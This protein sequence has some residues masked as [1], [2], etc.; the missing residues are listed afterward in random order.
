MPIIEIKLATTY[1]TILSLVLGFSTTGS[2]TTGS[3]TVG[4]STTGLSITGSSIFFVNLAKY[5]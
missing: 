4:S 2:S 3:S 1:I 5:F